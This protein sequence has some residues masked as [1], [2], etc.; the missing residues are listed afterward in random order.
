MAAGRLEGCVR[1]DAH[2][3]KND[4]GR[5]FPFTAG[6][7]KILADTSNDVPPPNTPNCRRW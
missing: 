7:D 1:L 3:T 5:S 2:A 6:L 4:E